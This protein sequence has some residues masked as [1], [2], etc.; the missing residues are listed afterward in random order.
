[1]NWSYLPNIIT[2]LRVILLFPLTYFLLVENYQVAVIIFFVAGF[3]DALDGYLAKRFSWVSRFGA[4]MDP[5][6]DKALLVLTM[7]ILTINQEISWPLFITV[8]VRD[9]YIVSGAYYY[10]WLL[11]PYEM[12]PSKLSK[13]NTFVQLLLVTT[14]MVSLG[15]RPLSEWLINFLIAM[16]FA[17]TISSGVHYTWVWGKKMRRELGRR[18]SSEQASTATGKD[19]PDMHKEPPQE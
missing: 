18:N 10:H 7:A 5:L 12:A 8:A 19:K 9:I 6:A 16:T 11:G 4:I 17:T 3:S 15:Y 2:V 1:M 13:L 14:L